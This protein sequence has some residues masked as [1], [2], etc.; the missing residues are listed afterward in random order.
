M[1]AISLNSEIF[2]V[3]VA[4]KSSRQNQVLSIYI[5]LM[6]SIELNIQIEIIIILFIKSVIMNREINSYF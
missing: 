5:L 2:L 4:M 6:I 1:H 3:L